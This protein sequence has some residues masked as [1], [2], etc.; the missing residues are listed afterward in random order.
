MGASGKGLPRRSRNRDL[1]GSIVPALLLLVACAGEPALEEPA[2][3]KE[4]VEASSAVDRAVATTGDVILYTVTIDYD[5]A[6]EIEVPEPGAD[7]A[8]FRIIDLGQEEPRSADGRIVEERWYELRADLVGSYVLPP[9]TV[10]YRRKAAAAA[11]D[12]PAEGEGEDSPEEVTASTFE[13]AQTSAIFVEVE[14]VLPQAGEGEATDIRDLKPLE[15]IASPVPWGWIAGSA[16]LLIGLLAGI[17]LW[18]RRPVKV[19]PPIPAHEIAFRELDGLRGTDFED[20]ESVRRFHFRISE[21]LRTYV[22]GRFGLNATDLTTEEILTELPALDGIAPAPAGDLR[23]FLEATD[24]VKFAHHTPLKEEIQETY[25]LGLG[26]VEATVPAAEG[27]TP[28]G[29]EEPA[30]GVPAEEAA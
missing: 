9:V 6:H 16:A 13:T 18:R 3:P 20:P 2:E 19:P 1:R 25:E 4:T 23:T 11:A 12:A 5:A 24:R 30:G 17:F 22:E 7:I 26:F 15:E 27:K 14:S 8:G 21:V 10:G 28:G 29:P